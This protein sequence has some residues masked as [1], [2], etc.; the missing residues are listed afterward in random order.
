MFPLGIAHVEVVD[1]GIYRVVFGDYA[2]GYGW[3]AIGECRVRQSDGA[4]V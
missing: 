1:L 2:T 4:R 3:R